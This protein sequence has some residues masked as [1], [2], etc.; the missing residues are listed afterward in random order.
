MRWQDAGVPV[1][2]VLAW[3]ITGVLAV[4]DW[5]AVLRDRHRVERWAKPAVM[6]GLGAV[7][8]A[9]GGLDTAT[10]WWVLAALALG[11]VGDVFL[12]GGSPAR[13]LGG[14]AAFL[15]GHLAWVGAFLATGLDAPGRGWVGAAIVVLALGAGHRIVPGA[16]REGGA[17]LG[18]P[19]VVYMVVIAAMAVAGWATGLTVVGVGAGLFVVSDTV[20]GLGRFDR[21]RRWTRPVVMVTYHSAQALIVAGLLGGGA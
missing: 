11:L 13:F 14:L 10:G 4:V 7:A 2:V 12:L 1:T 18:V 16:Y 19:V 17:A 21:E 6:V 3:V 8:V 20:L 5:W 9:S 15:V